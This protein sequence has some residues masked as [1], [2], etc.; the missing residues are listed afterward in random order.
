MQINLCGITLGSLLVT[1]E[2]IKI[3]T[4]TVLTIICANVTA[5]CNDY[6]NLKE[7]VEDLDKLYAVTLFHAEQDSYKEITQLRSIHGDT[8][9]DLPF[10]FKHA[11]WNKFKSKLKPGDCLYFFDTNAESWMNLSGRQGYVI[12][13][14][15]KIIDV[16]ITL[17]N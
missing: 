10:G 17:V 5:G 11:H 16:F 12:V 1:L 13:R 7:Q 8:I 6:V 3:I 15:G 2:G 4:F 14:S 9:P